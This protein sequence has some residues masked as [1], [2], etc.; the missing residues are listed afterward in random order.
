MLELLC[1]T[2]FGMN[3]NTFSEELLIVLLV[4][5]SSLWDMCW[6]HKISCSSW[7]TRSVSMLQQTKWTEEL[8]QVQYI[9]HV[10]ECLSSMFQP[11]VFIHF[12]ISVSASCDCFQQLR[13][14]QHCWWVSFPQAPATSQFTLSW[15]KLRLELN[16]TDRLLC[17]M[18]QDSPSISNVFH[19]SKNC[20]NF[21]ENKYS[22]LLF[23]LMLF[24]ISV[25]G[26]S[27]APGTK[28]TFYTQSRFQCSQFLYSL[29]FYQSH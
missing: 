16:D 14:R 8:K 29:R 2:S 20:L 11:L 7:V 27:K 23:F 5:C 25:T 6:D 18:E 9:L 4:S 17:F 21:T 12:K 26:I 13:I 3:K 28:H 22:L 10:H 15:V 1:L 19:T 24:H